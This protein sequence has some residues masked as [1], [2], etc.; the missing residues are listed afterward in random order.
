[1]TQA[2]H[3]FSTWIEA[4]DNAVQAQAK[5]RHAAV[6]AGEVAAGLAAMVLGV[7]AAAPV[8]VAGG[9]GLVAAAILAGALGAEALRRL[10]V[11]AGALVALVGAV[12][13]LIGAFLP[14][15]AV[16]PLLLA[17][18]AIVPLVQCWQRLFTPAGPDGLLYGAFSG[19]LMLA[20][21]FPFLVEPVA[22]HQML[23]Q[24]WPFAAAGAVV[25]GLVQLFCVL[26]AQLRGL[27]PEQP[28]E[29]VVLGWA[30]S[31]YLPLALTVP[32]VAWGLTAA[33][34]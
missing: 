14:G 13:A 16:W 21:A 24:V 26:A 17:A 11:W 6:V 7:A 28:P 32:A 19:G 30:V 15:G 25:A 1:M 34:G 18:G 2:V 20:L 4:R 9:P 27:E 10:P 12:W 33:L 23:V 31:R 8:S 3:Q 5:S 22:P 29:A